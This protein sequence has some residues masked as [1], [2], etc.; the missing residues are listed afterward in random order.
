[1]QAGRNVNKDAF[2]Q[3]RHAQEQIA[4]AGTYPGRDRHMPTDGK[5]IEL[6]TGKR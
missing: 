3:L 4:L 6:G 1:M 5:V 2:N